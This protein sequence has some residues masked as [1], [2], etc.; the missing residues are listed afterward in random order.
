MK[1]EP[2]YTKVEKHMPNVKAI[3]NEIERLEN[4][5]LDHNG[6]IS[7]LNLVRKLR[8]IKYLT[9]KVAFDLKYLAKKTEFSSDANPY[10]NYI[11]ENYLP[12]ME[13]R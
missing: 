13:H 11:A 5:L 8:S 2:I 9:R 10:G 6:D 4:D 12:E 1:Q 3:I 7:K